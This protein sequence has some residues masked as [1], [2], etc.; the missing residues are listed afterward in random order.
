M[1][2]QREELAR[3][4]GNQEY[5]LFAHLYDS[6]QRVRLLADAI[7]KAGWVSGAE[8]ERAR[9][10]SIDALAERDSLAKVVAAVEAACAKS[11]VAY[12]EAEEVV[13][14]DDLRAALS[15]ADAPQPEEKA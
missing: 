3:V 11:Y 5:D 2:E 7:I 1:S 15:A 10:V 13:L 12:E 9:K 4:I 6:P 14:L 8:V